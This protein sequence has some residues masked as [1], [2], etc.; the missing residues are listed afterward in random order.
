MSESGP[1]APATPISIHTEHGNVHGQ[2]TLPANTPS[3]SGLVVLAQAG[4]SPESYD[5]ALASV[6]RDAGLATLTIDLLAHQEEYFPD[7]H[8][9]VPLLTKRLL[10][11]LTLVKRQ[12]LN[13]E[14]PAVPIGLCA[15]GSGSPVVVR[16]AAVR[17]HDIAAIVCRGGLIDLAGM[18]YLRSLE[19]PLL[20]LVGESDER[21]VASNRR[22]LEEISCAKD[23]EIIPGTD[24]QF[25]STAAFDDVAQ[26]AAQW[27]T[28]H[29]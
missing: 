12:M 26:R 19:S 14:L 20:V 1:D 17:D 22:A 6:F 10:D 7:A 9:N 28:G 18:L 21:L 15:S 24:S 11:C 8:H 13:E 23:L 3:A 25:A 2:L 5:E 27:F 16:V 29:F 4:M